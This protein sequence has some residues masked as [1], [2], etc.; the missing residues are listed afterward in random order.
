VSFL[1]DL[2]ERPAVHDRHAH[3]QQDEPG[4]GLLDLGERLRPSAAPTTG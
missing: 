1:Q 2:G 3:I 4:P